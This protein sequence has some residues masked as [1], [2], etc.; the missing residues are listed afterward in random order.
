MNARTL[1]LKTSAAQRA[2]GRAIALGAMVGLMALTSACNQQQFGVQSVNQQFDQQVTYAKDV[3]VLWVIDTSRSMDEHQ[4]L[5]AQQM[6]IFVDALK[7]TELN[8]QIAATTM[9][10][11]SGGEKGKFVAQDGTPAILRGDNPQLKSLLEGRIRLGQAGSLVER[12]REAMKAALSSP[13]ITTGPNQGFLRPNA[14]LVVIFLT[15]EEDESAETDYAGFL[16]QIRPP[17]A[18]G[19]RS[20]IA[21]FMGVTPDDP[22]CKTSKFDYSSVGY[23]YIDLVNQSSGAVESICDANFARALTNVKARV[24]EIATEF[25]LDRKPI[26]SSIRV[27]VNGQAVPESADNGWTYFEANNSIRFHGTAVPKPGSGIK[28]DFDPDGLK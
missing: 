10:M 1:I 16:D 17:L 14:L 9:D 26:I 3:D 15:N 13:N 27:V 12:G 8:F 7:G 18:S 22:S 24:L 11:G 2:T 20:W 6:D 5:L 4:D 19:E 28:I 25:K 23:K 21:H